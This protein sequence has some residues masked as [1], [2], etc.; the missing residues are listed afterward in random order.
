MIGVVAQQIIGQATFN[1]AALGLA[2]VQNH[3]AHLLEQLVR[4]RTRIVA[5]GQ[6]RHVLHGQALVVGG[7]LVE[8]LARA[9]RSTHQQLVIVQ[10]NPQLIGEDTANLVALGAKV[11]RDGNDHRTK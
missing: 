3:L 1:N 6:K 8:R 4:V 9:Q 5:V 10:R 11:A 7:H 2:Q